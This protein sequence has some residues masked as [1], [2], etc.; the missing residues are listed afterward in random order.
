MTIAII[1][2]ENSVN[3]FNS[4]AGI[5]KGKLINLNFSSVSQ[6]CLTLCDPVDCSIPAFPAHHQLLE[7][8]QTHVHRGG[9]AI[10]PSCVLEETFQNK[11]WRE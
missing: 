10:Q 8:A 7:V 5:A 9:D 1:E 3:G 11:T 2:I 6:L 4:K